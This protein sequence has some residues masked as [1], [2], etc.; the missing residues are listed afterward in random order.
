VVDVPSLA[1]AEHTLRS[2]V[3]RL[4][5]LS[6]SQQYKF[7]RQHFSA[8]R[9]LL[10][11][12]QGVSADKPLPDA[13]AER[14][15]QECFLAE[16]TALPRSQA[17][18]EQLIAQHRGELNDAIERLG[19]TA[20]AL[21]KELRTVRQALSSLNAPAVQQA[22]ADIQTQLATLLPD[23]FVLSIPAPWFSQVP[24]YL[25]AVSRRL[26]RLP[27]NVVRD[28]ELAKQVQP[29]L[30][31]YRRLT[32]AHAE[33]LPAVEKLKWMIEEFRVSL[34]AQDL[35]TSVSVSAKRLGEQVELSS[36]DA[37]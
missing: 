25:K 21:F 7:A 37:G 26:E 12:G 14:A 29:F 24:R 11:L 34:F 36:R 27:G 5:V 17:A 16:E 22:V 10:L 15:L 6:L 9:E 30:I 33:K 28:A 18:F 13:L 3:R 4:L 31:A 20:L 23:G 2:G 32:E 35:R 19:N 1:Q 8:N